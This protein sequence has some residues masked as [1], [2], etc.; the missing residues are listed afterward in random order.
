MYVGQK[1]PRRAHNPHNAGTPT[2]VACCSSCRSSN[3]GSR[4]ISAT[5]SSSSGASH[6][7]RIVLGI[8]TGSTVTV[9][10]TARE[11]LS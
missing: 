7:F 11:L 9:T 10:S 1:H 6:T 3:R 2:T 4:T 5:T 8:R